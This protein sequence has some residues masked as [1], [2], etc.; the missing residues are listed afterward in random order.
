MLLSP[1]ND[2]HLFTTCRKGMNNLW[3]CNTLY[4][5]FSFQCIFFCLNPNI[6]KFLPNFAKIYA[7]NRHT[8][9]RLCAQK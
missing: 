7:R 4:T 2:K 6:S 8:I 3:N 5:F 1:K 9:D